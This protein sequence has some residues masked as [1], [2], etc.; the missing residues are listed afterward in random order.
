MEKLYADDR[1]IGIVPD[2]NE[3]IEV[4]SGRTSA[5][6]LAQRFVSRPTLGHNCRNCGAPL[7]RNGDCV[8]CGTV[9][10]HHSSMVMTQD[11][12]MFYC[13]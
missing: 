2:D 11:A 6:T 5:G 7:D 9:R 1:L 4:I 8:F 13:E 12:I 10:Q 3:V